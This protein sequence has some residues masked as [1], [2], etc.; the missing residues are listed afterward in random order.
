MRCEHLRQEA[1]QCEKSQVQIALEESTARLV[2]AQR[3]MAALEE[4]ASQQLM[5]AIDD[6]AQQTQ[7]I[8]NEA[9]EERALIQQEIAG[10]EAAAEEPEELECTGCLNELAP[11]TVRLACGHACFCEICLVRA[12]E[13]NGVCPICR[14][15]IA[16]DSAGS[17][18]GVL[19]GAHIAREPAYIEPPT[20]RRGSA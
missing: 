8:L 9:F 3:Q 10:Q 12:L 6:A 18:Q 14:S 15:P 16:T 17:A 4:N 7:Q 13:A 1:A 2:N 19:R 20:Y 11:V 5:W